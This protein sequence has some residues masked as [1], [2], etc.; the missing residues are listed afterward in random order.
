MGAGNRPGNGYRTMALGGGARNR[1]W[2][3]FGY[4]LTSDVDRHFGY[5]QTLGCGQTFRIRT[6][7]LGCEQTFVLLFFSSVFRFLSAFVSC[8]C[9]CK[10]AKPILIRNVGRS[11]LS[12]LMH[13][14]PE[15]NK[16]THTERTRRSQLSRLESSR[17]GS[18]QMTSTPAVRNP[19][20]PGQ[21]QVRRPQAWDGGS[22]VVV[23]SLRL[24]TEPLTIIYSTPVDARRPRTSLTLCALHP[25]LPG[26][27]HHQH[28]SLFQQNRALTAF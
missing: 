12:I 21:S 17:D 2:T 6:W 27:L 18:D 1:M 10:P 4:G 24:R 11:A 19:W 3:G 20:E 16:N 13:D 8:F 14:E 9:V 25:S 7:I 15:H 28:R 23:H 5:A 26:T 22:V